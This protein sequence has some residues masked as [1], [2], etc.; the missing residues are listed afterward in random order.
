MNLKDLL[1]E[2][3]D[4][5]SGTLNDMKPLS[6]RE[7]GTITFS[8]TKDWIFYGNPNMGMFHATFSGAIERFSQVAVRD[9][10]ELWYKEMVDFTDQFMQY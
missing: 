5:V 1:Q 6:W 7:K 2:D 9:H 4:Q 3:P 10:G 8:A